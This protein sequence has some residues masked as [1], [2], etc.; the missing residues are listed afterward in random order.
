MLAGFLGNRCSI[1]LSYGAAELIVI[2]IVRFGFAQGSMFRCE[3]RLRFFR[4]AARGQKC[5]RYE[6]C[7]DLLP[8]NTIR[9]GGQDRVRGEFWDMEARSSHTSEPFPAVVVPPNT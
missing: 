1:H 3:P 8:P 6:R 4:E 2:G 7:N 9:A 5:P